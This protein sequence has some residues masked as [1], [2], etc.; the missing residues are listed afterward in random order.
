[1]L[2][3]G[4]VLSA[5]AAAYFI[6]RYHER[7]VSKAL[8]VDVLAKHIQVELDAKHSVVVAGPKRPLRLRRVK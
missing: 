8:M 6:G 7:L 4:I 5:A 2:T 3:V 1:M